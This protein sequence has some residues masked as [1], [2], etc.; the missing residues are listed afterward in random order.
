MCVYV[1]VCMYMYVC[2]YEYV[3]VCMHVCVCV[4]MYVHVFVGLYVCVC[5]CVFVRVT[6]SLFQQRGGGEEAS[7]YY[8]NKGKEASPYI[9]S[10]F[11]GSDHHVVGA[12]QWLFFFIL[13]S[14]SKCSDKLLDASS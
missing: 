3:Y 8:F 2:M 14:I 1:Y 7:L 6:I 5:V 13:K 9:R 11:D 10:R 4:C 12:R